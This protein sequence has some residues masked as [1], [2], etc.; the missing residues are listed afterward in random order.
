MGSPL[1]LLCN[2]VRVLIIPG[3]NNSGADHWQTWL[4]TQ[5]QDSRRVH[6]ADWA[7]PDLAAWSEQ[8][9]HTVERSKPGT[10]W[11]AV[12][13][14]FG[15]LAL[16]HHLDKASARGHESNGTGGRIHAALLVAPADPVKFNV[17]QHLPH[18]GLGIPSLMI[19]S[20][21]DP[22]M[23]LDR[24]QSWA[25]RWGS[26]FLNLGPAGHINAESGHGAWPLA[27]LKVDELIRDQ[28]RQRRLAQVSPMD[29]QYAV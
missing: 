4:G 16:A 29:L 8:I 17:V 6:Q 27:R 10:V 9:D 12:A 7:H 3:L 1:P 13:H 14:S 28:H 11:V 22:W 19:G 25:K 18:T 26:R 20:E 2:P 15:C 21:N 23:S 24:A 5:Y